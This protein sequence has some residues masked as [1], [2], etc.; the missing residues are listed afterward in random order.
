MST[1]LC[2]LLYVD[3]SMST[4][5]CRLLYVDCS[6][7]TALCQLLYVNC[8]MSSAQCSMSSAQCSMSTAQCSMS[9]AQCSMS[10]A[11]FRDLPG[12]RS[13]GTRLLYAIIIASLSVCILHHY[14]IIIYM[15]V[16]LLFISIQF[17]EQEKQERLKQRDQNF[18]ALKKADDTPL[19]T[20]AEE[21][22]CQICITP[23]PAGEGVIL[24]G[25]L[26]EF[27]RSVYRC[28]EECCNFRFSIFLVASL[29]KHSSPIQT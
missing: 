11:L 23:V 3:C 21:F 14:Y 2:R 6:M 29:D 19:N 27:C 10:T 22:E 13:L 1:A 16:P 25:C 9:T 26:H 28:Y 15:Y 5:L 24:R 4:A 8:S 17:F 7:S 18:A 20:N 12:H